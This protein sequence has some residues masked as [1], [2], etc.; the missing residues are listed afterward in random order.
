ML[1]EWPRNRKGKESPSESGRV[2]SAEGS[3]HGSVCE[4]AVK[5][6]GPRIFHA[7]LDLASR[8]EQNGQV[9]Q[10]AE[11]YV[12]LI[13][14]Y[15]ATAEAKVVEERVMGFARRLEAG[16]KPRLA[17]S[18]YRKLA[19]SFAHRDR[20]SGAS[21]EQG[22]MAEAALRLGGNGTSRPLDS[23][24]EIPFVDLTRPARVKQNF[25]RLGQLWRSEAEISRAV[26]MLRE[27]K[28]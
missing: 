17:L 4:D 13:W 12:S 26:S 16:G 1:S 9:H 11:I 3:A 24:G 28:R 22:A 5:Q 10:A 15:P 27:L 25:E 20:Q 14:Q 23:A 18:L 21:P 19:A 7:L 8:H 2:G 6:E